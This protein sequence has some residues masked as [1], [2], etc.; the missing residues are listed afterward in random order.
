[1]KLL[2]TSTRA[3][4]DVLMICERDRVGD[5]L[6]N[7]D[8]PAHY[9]KMAHPDDHREDEEPQPMEVFYHRA[10]SHHNRVLARFPFITKNKTFISASFV[11]DT[12]APDRFYLGDRYVL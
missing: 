5:V 10:V 6:L 9:V 2:C 11:L 4:K 12:G 1:M 3:G 8:F 7:E